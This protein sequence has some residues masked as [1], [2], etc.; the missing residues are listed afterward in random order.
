MTVAALLLAGGES[1]RMGTPKPLLEWGPST[2]LRAGAATLIE[3][4]IG[5][6]KRA[7]ID[8]VV[9]VLGAQADEVRPYVHQAG[10]QAVINELY[11]SGRASSLRVGAAALDDDV[12]AIVVINV[13]QPR[14][15]QV[16]ARL[17]RSHLEAG[18]VVTIPVHQ[19]KRGHPPVLAGSLLSEL[20]E[21]REETLGL[22]EILRRHEDDVRTVDFDTPVVLLDINRPADYEKALSYYFR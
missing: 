21:A 18:Q 11:R 14:P 9:V 4:Q 20:R 19:G 12:E 10:A 16:L 13:D 15:H 6:L 1:S 17:V 22:R 2:R 8:K 5:Q 7:G 3:Y